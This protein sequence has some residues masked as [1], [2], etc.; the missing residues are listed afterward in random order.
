MNEQIVTWTTPCMRAEKAL[1]AAGEHLTFNRRA[2]A[3][4]KIH[5]TLL[6]LRDLIAQVEREELA[7]LEV[8][9]RQGLA[10]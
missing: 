6:H 8:R 9:R 3:R 2:E 7:S 5:E 10:P 4:D 1:A